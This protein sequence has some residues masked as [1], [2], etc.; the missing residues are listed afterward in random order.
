MKGEPERRLGSPVED[1]ARHAELEPFT[2]PDLSSGRPEAAPLI[3]AIP[4]RDEEDRI[5]RTLRALGQ[6]HGEHGGSLR[7]LVLANNCT[8]QTAAEVRRVARTLACPV[9]VVEESFAPQLAHIGHARGQALTLA[10]ARLEDAPGGLLATTDADTVVAHDWALWLRLAFARADVVAG[11]I[12]TLP[13]ESACLPRA[14]R[15]L[16]L[17]DAAYHLLCAQVSSRLDPDPHD[18][19]PRHHQHF[20][21]N[22]ALRLSA[23]RRLSGWPG[24][25]C[26]EDVALVREL[27]RLDLR[28]RH[29]PAVRA[30]TSAREH[31]RVEVGLSSQ[32][33]EWSAL[34]ARDEPWRVPGAEEVWS[35]ALAGAALR[36]AWS[37]R[38]TEGR[39]ETTGEDT[40]G[41]L[42]D[43]WLIDRNALREAL[44][45]P[46]LGEARERALH[47]R[48]AAGRWSKRYPP[49]PLEQALQTLRLRLNRPD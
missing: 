20:G 8:D 25:R 10:A 7:V 2:E 31:G 16:Q 24:G 42:Q 34:Q 35:A 46:T 47:D 1:A 19:W 40:L 33:R 45:A 44:M 38:A 27:R 12:L 18:P 17:Q 41:A 23:W 5:A 13:E 48:H 32:L 9:E 37:A 6:Q 49:V 4:A 14:L 43:L 29:C 39:N 11:R 28:I 22:L 21:A 26:L 30:W 15:R 3:V 36:R